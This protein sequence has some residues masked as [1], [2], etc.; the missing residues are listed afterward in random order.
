[1]GLN[2]IKYIMSGIKYRITLKIKDINNDWVFV[3]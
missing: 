2:L 3:L 1:M